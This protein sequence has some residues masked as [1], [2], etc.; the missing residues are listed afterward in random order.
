M[1]QL[2][3]R[4]QSHVSPHEA[5]SLGPAYYHSSLLPPFK[6]YYIIYWFYIF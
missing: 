5:M 1:G 2:T 4:A 6:L 3:K